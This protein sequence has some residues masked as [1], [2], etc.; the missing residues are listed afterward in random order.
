MTTKRELNEQA[1]RLFSEASTARSAANR[2]SFRVN[3]RD[4]PAGEDTRK[5]LYFKFT[6]KEYDRN[7]VLWYCHNCGNGGLF[8]HDKFSGTQVVLDP[9]EEGNCEEDKTKTYGSSVWTRAVRIG[10]EFAIGERRRLPK[11]HVTYLVRSGWEPADQAY[12]AI[13]NSHVKYDPY[14]DQLVFALRKDMAKGLASAPSEFLSAIQVRA[15]RQGQPKCLTIKFSD[16]SLVNTM[17]YAP[18]SGKPHKKPIVV[19]EDMMSG[20][21]LAYSGYK[22]FVLCGSHMS[23]REFMAYP[24][25]LK[26]DLVVWLDNDNDQ[27][28]KSAEYI[29]RLHSTLTG[30]AHSSRVIL[31]HS[32]PKHYPAQSI[33]HILHE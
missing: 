27:V 25:L 30:G 5:R 4:C 26:S 14:E 19:V 23:S 21:K 20:I 15:N 16:D 29:S 7:L 2:A 11:N 31:N 32:D 33:R 18:W 3:H 22:A 8:K 12:L 6:D 28:C 17:V 9:I 13:A 10:E 24:A 1:R